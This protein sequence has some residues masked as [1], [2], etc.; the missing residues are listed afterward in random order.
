M[1][2]YTDI[3]K[4]VQDKYEVLSGECGLFWAFSNEQFA[5]GKLKNPVAEGDKYVSIGAGGYMPK[6]NWQRFVD[7]QKEIEKWRKAEVK[8]AKATEVILYE[9]NNYEC[10]YTGEITD[11]L[12]VLEPLGY[13]AA[14]VREVYHANREFALN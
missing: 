2:N 7:G 6:A 13:T 5:E 4:Q 12:E 9:L 14:Q 1:T 3:K 8:K 11:A 10:F